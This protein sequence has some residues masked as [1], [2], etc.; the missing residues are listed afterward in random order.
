LCLFLGF[1][2]FAPCLVVNSASF[3]LA[4]WQLRYSG[5]GLYPLR[6]P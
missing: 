6:L 5:K 1:I 4:D 3:D 2:S